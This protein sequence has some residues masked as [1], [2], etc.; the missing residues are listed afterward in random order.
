MSFAI[1]GQKSQIMQERGFGLRQLDCEESFLLEKK[2]KIHLMWLS[3]C[4]WL[5]IFKKILGLALVSK[6]IHKQYY[7]AAKALDSSIRLWLHYVSQ[8][9][10]GF[11]WV[12][13]CG[14]KAV[15]NNAT[16][17]HQMMDICKSADIIWIGCVLCMCANWNMG[18]N[19]ANTIFR[20]RKK[21]KDD[22]LSFRMECSS[23]IVCVV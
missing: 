23:K 11:N 4:R 6:P 15:V 18:Y 13:I 1:I 9:L 22:F 17:T 8:H 7:I 16:F 20:L 19:N 12:L 5:C 3:P 2:V 14:D 10:I 21:A